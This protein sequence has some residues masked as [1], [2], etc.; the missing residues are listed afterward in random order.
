MKKH[1]IK[2]TWIQVFLDP[3][4]L[5]LAITAFVVL[6]MATTLLYFV[7]VNIN[8]KMTSYFD[9]IWWG[10]AT[11]TTIGYGDVVPITL[12]GRIIGI[13][14]MMTGPALFVLF[15]GA[16]W[17]SVLAEQA[18]EISPLDR[19]IHQ[20]IKHSQQLE[21]LLQEINDRLKSLE[22]KP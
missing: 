2:I 12:T 18:D 3:I 8:P 7:E 14:L 4:F 13:F 1:R 15:T 16:L 9:S 11:I 19:S 17:R 6:L 5:T 22:R 20:E 10:V 21:A